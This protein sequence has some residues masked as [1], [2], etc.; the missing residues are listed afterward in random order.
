MRRIKLF[1]PKQMDV[2]H[3][4][5]V[6]Y[7]E[8]AGIDFFDL[9]LEPSEFALPD[10]LRSQPEGLD[11]ILIDGWHTFDQMMLNLFYANRLVRVGGYIVVDDCDWESVSAAVSYYKNYPAFEQVKEPTMIAHSWG[12][13]VARIITTMFPS[14]L[15]RMILPASIYGSIYRRMIFRSMVAFKK[16]SADTRSWTWFVG[17]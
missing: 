7:L 14:R 5:G 6:T 15:A 11:L 10:L 1:D 8:R 12:Q 9:M 17:F 16:V 3:G 2:W 13:N 4:V